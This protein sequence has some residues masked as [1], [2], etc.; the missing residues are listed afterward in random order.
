[1]CD[2]L[3]AVHSKGDPGAA[4]EANTAE[5]TS[6]NPGHQPCLSSGGGGYLNKISENHVLET[7]PHIC[8]TVFTHSGHRILAK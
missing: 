5:H 1:M 6:R 8:P 7:F 3:E 2:I 4:P